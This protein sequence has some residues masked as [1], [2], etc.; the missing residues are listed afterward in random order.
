MGFEHQIFS[1]SGSGIIL[2]CTLIEYYEE[3]WEISKKGGNKGQK[4]IGKEE[5]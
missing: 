4:L 3:A 2:C 5:K 1:G